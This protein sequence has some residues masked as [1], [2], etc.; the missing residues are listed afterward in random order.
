[1]GS[2]DVQRDKPPKIVK[3]KIYLRKVECLSDKWPRYQDL[4]CV[5][6]VH[7]KG[8]IY[9]LVVTVRASCLGTR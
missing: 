4:A 1:M 6:P 2:E 5:T 9:S 3:L 7:L 8:N